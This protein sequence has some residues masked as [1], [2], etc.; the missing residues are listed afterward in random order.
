VTADAP[1][2]RPHDPVRARRAQIV[3]WAKVVQRLGYLLYLV[4]TVAFSIGLVRG[5]DGGLV[6]VIEIGLIGGSIVLAPAIL[7]AY[8]AKAAERD[9]L[10]HGR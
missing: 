4:A 5:F 7:V 3:R 1:S 8:M 2:P 10:E 6:T 9:D